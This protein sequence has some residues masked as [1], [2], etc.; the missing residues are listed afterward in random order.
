M[1]KNVY[2]VYDE[3]AE[4]Y[5]NPFYMLNDKMALRAFKD[6]AN[7]PQSTIYNNP[8]DFSLYLIAEYDD[9]T[10]E[11]Q[12]MIPIKIIAKATEVKHETTFTLPEGQNPGT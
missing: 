11:T 4:L 5:N 1:K 10:A 3:K 9:S 7:D 12:S 6:L 8:S 2:A